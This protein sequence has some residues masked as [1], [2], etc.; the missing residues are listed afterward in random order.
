MTDHSGTAVF[1]TVARIVLVAVAWLGS[2]TL[3]HV[4]TVVAIISG[5]LVIIYT[6][7]QAYLLWR[8]RIRQQ[9]KAGGTD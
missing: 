8:D 9:P 1:D 5:M 4:Q 2:V 3:A 6:G 7:M